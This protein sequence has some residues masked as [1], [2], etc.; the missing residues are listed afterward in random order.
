MTSC[1]LSGRGGQLLDFEPGEGAVRRPESAGAP[2]LEVWHRSRWLPAGPAA[3]ATMLPCPP[4]AGFR[5]PPA[6]QPPR[7]SR[8]ARLSGLEPRRTPARQGAA[9][10]AAAPYREAVSCL[11]RRRQSEPPPGTPGEHAPTGKTIVE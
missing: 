10:R 9:R 6:H 2:L 7:P 4:T 3:E 11:R 5:A 1:P 8:E